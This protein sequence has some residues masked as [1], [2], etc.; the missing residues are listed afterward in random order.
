M[1]QGDSEKVATSEQA[2]FRR[3]E[4]TAAGLLRHQ[5]FKLLALAL[6]R[7]RGYRPNSE[8]CVVAVSVTDALCSDGDV[9]FEQSPMR[10]LPEI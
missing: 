5:F 10:L 1:H 4:Y 2:D 9:E 7:S 8:S 3:L 6:T